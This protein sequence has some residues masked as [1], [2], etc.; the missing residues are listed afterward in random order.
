[1][2]SLDYDIKCNEYRGKAFCLSKKWELTPSSFFKNTEETPAS[3]FKYKYD[4]ELGVIEIYKY[5]G[6][7][8]RVYI[9]E[10]ING[11]PVTAIYCNCFN[12]SD[13]EFVY[14]PKSIIFIDDMIFNNPN[15]RITEISVD[16][17]NEE[18]SSVDGI[19]FNKEKN[20]L[21]AY[22]SGNRQTSYE[23]PNDVEFIGY[24]AFFNCIYLSF[25]KLP[26]GLKHIDDR[27]FK[28]CLN[29]TDITIPDTVKY[30]GKEAFCACENLSQEFHNIIDNLTLNSFESVLESNSEC[31][32]ISKSIVEIREGIFNHK[33]SIINKIIVDEHNYGFSSEDGVLFNKDKTALISYP[34]GKTQKSYTVPK[35]V[36]HICRSAF[37]YCSNLSSIELPYGLIS[38]DDL[39]FYDCTAIT[40]LIIPNSVVDIGEHAFSGCKNL[41]SVIL[42]DNMTRIRM[43]LFN[44]CE[45][46]TDVVFP[47]SIKRIETPFC[48]HEVHLFHGC[49]KMRNVVIPNSV[50]S[51][52]K[53]LFYG[54]L[55]DISVIYKGIT[56]K[57][58]KRHNRD[59]YDMPQEFY[60][61]VNGKEKKNDI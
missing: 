54:E 23:I 56:Y 17:N 30:I 4:E 1:M 45:N 43:Q 5:T 14:I 18:Y 31:V 13:V 15:G 8:M 19:L 51:V 3:D 41:E 44:G 42:S 9:P 40:N 57:S 47:N 21:L 53:R 10:R 52:G 20:T 29:L 55:P 24:M 61:A 58:E 36:K 39:A 32:Y 37:S 38:I 11:N 33:D 27:A 49:K 16:K 60:D 48:G 46:L 6:A 12:G 7:S 26:H 22:P 25:V 2:S 28:C 59:S 50:T 34:P 35:S